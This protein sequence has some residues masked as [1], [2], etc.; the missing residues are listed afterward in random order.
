MPGTAI[1]RVFN[2]SSG[3]A[4]LP[5]E[6]LE[7]AQRD[8]LALPGVGMSVLEISH[9]SKPF[10]EIIQNAEADIREL[11]R[12]PDNYHVLFLQGGAS[13]QF[14]MIPMNLLPEGGTADYIVTGVWSQKAVKEA[15]RHGA[16]HVAAST[17]AGNFTRVPRQDEIAL[18]G[19]GA[20]VHVTS[21]NTIYGTQFRAMPDVGAAPLICDASSDIFSRPID[22][23]QYG[24][25]YAGAQKNLGPSGV[26]LVIVRDDLV[27][28]SPAGL[29]TMLSYAVQAE[30]KSL[31]NTPPV[32]GIY[33]LGLVAKW[34]KR[35]GLA[36][37][38]TIN[39]RKAAK[40]YAEIDRTGFYRGHA[41]PDSRSRMNITFRLPSE[42][43][44]KQ[45]VKESTAAGFDGLKGHRSVGGLRA[46]IYN[47]FP[48]A[49]VDQLVEFMREFERTRG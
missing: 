20:Y 23:S 45:F 9:R 33:I 25:L 30:N 47:A 2:F 35:V 44:E 21:N 3:P 24:L 10:D 42:E 29:P 7:E 36:S 37:V 34:M 40:L 12:I 8:L 1:Q 15:K 18:S 6:V 41:E 19:T 49:G 48:E 16:V 28:R 22:V 5:L 39:E 46:S 17:E 11:G 13:L 4:V 14:S 43:L 31:Y 38:E 26:T 27:K 32:F